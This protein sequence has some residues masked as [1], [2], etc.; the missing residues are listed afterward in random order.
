MMDFDRKHEIM[1]KIGE[2]GGMYRQMLMMQQQMMMLAQMVDQVKGTNMAE[3]IAAGVT[4]GPAPAIIDGSDV[5]EK[6]QQALG[7]GEGGKE[8]SVTRNARKRVAEST[9]PT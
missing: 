4:G 5:A 9:D 8:S 6:G 1:Q 3:Q 7:G 2:N